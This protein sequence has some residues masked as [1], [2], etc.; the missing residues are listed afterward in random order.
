MNS[1]RSDDDQAD[2][3]PRIPVRVVAWSL[4]LVSILSLWGFRP[5]LKNGFVDWDDHIYLGE[6]ARMGQFSW[7]SMVWMW[8]SLEPFYLQP[9]VWMTHLADY[10]I[11]GLNPVGHHATNWIF[12]GV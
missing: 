9:I 12:H 1:T 8:T 11:W 5:A 6:L 10:Q 2:S 3:S 4:A 7:S